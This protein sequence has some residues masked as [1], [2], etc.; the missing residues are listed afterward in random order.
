[1]V[2]FA[3]L[4]QRGLFLVTLRTN[5]IVAIDKVLAFADTAC[6]RT[7]IIDVSA[8]KLR[9]V[10]I[11]SLFISTFAVACVVVEVIHTI[12]KRAACY[13]RAVIDIQALVNDAR[14]VTICFARDCEAQC[15]V[16][17]AVGG[18]AIVAIIAKHI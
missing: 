5:A 15:P 6:F 8:D 7:A 17:A 3:L 12:S 18:V 1:V 11:P 13:V 2:L 9:C 14:K 16:G 10:R 4:V